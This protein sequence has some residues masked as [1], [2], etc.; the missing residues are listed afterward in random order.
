MIKFTTGNMFDAEVEALVNTVN[1]VGVMGK[2][3]ALE[4]K[5]RFPEIFPPYRHV[6]KNNN[7]KVGQMLPF[8]LKTNTFPYYIINFPTKKHWKNNS[9]IEYIESGLDSFM[10]LLIRWDIKSVAVPPL[11]CGNGGLEW[12]KVK[13]LIQ[14]KHD[15][16]CN[17][18][19][20]KTNIVVYEP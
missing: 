3:V 12:N 20:L 10:N 18:H 15:A 6:C 17:L 4:C 14:S 16:W 7:L 1:C 5:K 11:G 9:K 13:Q 19:Q 2:G 8:R